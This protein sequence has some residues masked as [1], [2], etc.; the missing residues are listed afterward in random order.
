MSTLLDQSVRS[1]PYLYGY[2]HH[3]INTNGI[4]SRAWDVRSCPV[5]KNAPLTSLAL[6]EKDYNRC[7]EP[8]PTRIG[9]PQAISH[10]FY[11]R[12]N[13]DLHGYMLP[14]RYTDNTAYGAY[15]AGLLFNAPNNVT[16]SNTNDDNEKKKML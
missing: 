9:F 4:V 15:A 1:S 12:R 6:I 8:L 2:R 11:N 14:H 5:G 13:L 16:N 7:H 10:R 3:R